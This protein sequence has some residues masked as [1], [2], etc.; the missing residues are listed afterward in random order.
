MYLPCQLAEF[1][2]TRGKRSEMKSWGQLAVSK[3]KP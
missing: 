2:G 1:T 3:G